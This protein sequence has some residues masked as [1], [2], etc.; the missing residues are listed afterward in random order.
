ME[1]N[2]LKKIIT[3]YIKIGVVSYV[4]SIIF[5]FY[6]KKSLKRRKICAKIPNIVPDK[7]F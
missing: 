7:L 2:Y 4:I 3:Y 5:A 1:N 6:S